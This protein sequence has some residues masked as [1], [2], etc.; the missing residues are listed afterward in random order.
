MNVVFTVTFSGTPDADDARSASQIVFIENQK[1]EATSPPGTPLAVDT[2]ANLKASYLSLL[3]AQVTA[4]HAQNILI[5]K[6]QAIGSRFT[7]AKLQQIFGNLI[8]QLNAGTSV[9]AVI[10]KTV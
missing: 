4:I 6:T 1:R 7:G 2:G 5:S 9:A 10:A 3:T 8:D